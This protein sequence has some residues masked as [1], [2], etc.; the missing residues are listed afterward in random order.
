MLI[1]KHC[2]SV[3][4]R[5]NSFDCSEDCDTFFRLC[6]CLFLF[7]QTAARLTCFE[8]DD[9][10]IIFLFFKE[11]FHVLWAGV[12]CERHS[13][14]TRSEWSYEARQCYLLHPFA[15]LKYLVR[16]IQLEASQ[17]RQQG[18]GFNVCATDCLN[19]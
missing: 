9:I 3:Y 13:E 15:L 8:P 11:P 7:W 12:M 10:F 1:F 4:F 18:V 16:I 6:F 2:Y 17:H 5:L 19:V 14:H